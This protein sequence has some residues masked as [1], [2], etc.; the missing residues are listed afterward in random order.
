MRAALG[1]AVREHARPREKDVGPGDGAIG[2]HDGPALHALVACDQL[3]EGRHAYAVRVSGGPRGGV[4]ATG[5]CHRRY[6]PRASHPRHRIAP[7]R[8]GL[9]R[10]GARGLAAR[11]GLRL[12]A[13]QHPPP[14]GDVRRP[15]PALVSVRLQRERGRRPR[16]GRRDARMALR[17][18]RGAGERCEG[19]AT[20]PAWRATHLA[21]A[22]NRR[23]HAVPLL[24]D[25]IAVFSVEWLHD[26]FGAEPVLLV[27]HPAAFAASVKRLHLRHPFGDF[28]AQPLMMRD[29]LSSFA[30]ELERF[31]AREQEI[32]DQAILL[33][34]VIHHALATYRARHP[35]WA[36]L[37]LEDISRQPAAEFHALFD[38]LG[39]PRDDAR[40]RPDRLDQRLV[41]PGRGEHRRLDPARQRGP[42][43]E[44][45]ADAR[46][47]RDRP[48]ARGHRG[49]SRRPST[50]PTT[51]ERPFSSPGST[52]RARPGW[53]TPWPARPASP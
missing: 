24:K 21:S 35:E 41:E 4:N 31:A 49:E 28:L 8:H 5:P 18:R 17:L 6:C 26:T 16:A 27:R 53:A 15:V 7:L 42:H 2:G 33:W 9:G 22:Q 1:E 48:R 37:R 13:V 38:R 11:A 32:V 51:G 52:G 43:L 20:P 10:T 46:R 29:W 45:E 34:N 12:G 36:L 50:G 14:A 3:R 44:L 40:G 47:G 25:P 39:V 30:D 19:R 23:R